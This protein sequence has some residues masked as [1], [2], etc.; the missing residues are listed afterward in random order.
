MYITVV[1][2]DFMGHLN[3]SVRCLEGSRD[4]DGRWTTLALGEIPLPEV[5]DGN[6][7]DVLAVVAEQL[8]DVAY[9]RY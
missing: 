6:P 4:E 1:A 5:T 2:Y 7:R 8:L 9:A 3:Y